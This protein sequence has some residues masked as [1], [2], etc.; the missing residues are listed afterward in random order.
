MNKSPF[1]R[2]A[3][4]GV[5]NSVF[6]VRI[7]NALARSHRDPIPNSGRTKPHPL[8][9]RA[10]SR[11]AISTDTAKWQSMGTC[12]AWASA[13]IT[14]FF[15]KMGT[16]TTTTPKKQRVYTIKG[17]TIQ[18]GFEKPEPFKRLK[19]TLEID[20]DALKILEPLD[21]L[22]FN[23]KYESISAQGAIVGTGGS[24]ST[25]NLALRKDGRFTRD[26]DTGFFFGATDT[27]TSSGNV[28][29]S[30]GGSSSRSNN[31]SYKVYGNTIEYKYD[32]GRIV[33]QFMFLPIGRKDLTFMHIG[34]R[35]YW[36]PDK[37]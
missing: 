28:T 24:S 29:A 13:T 4:L 15:K 30:V 22:K 37:K 16:F 7:V 36:V 18:I 1:L 2:K 11:G 20:G 34:G 32:D 35:A 33:K 23:N 14:G 17:N 27:G 21:G 19:N 8:P 25:V 6:I 12:P 5:K 9:A 10:D 26:V 3:K 31:G